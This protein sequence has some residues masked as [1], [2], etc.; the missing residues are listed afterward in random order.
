MTV[1]VVRDI[2]FGVSMANQ[3]PRIPIVCSSRANIGIRWHIK[4]FEH[5]EPSFYL[6]VKCFRFNSFLFFLAFILSRSSEPLCR[7]CLWNAMALC[8]ID[9]PHSLFVSMP[10]E[11]SW[12]SSI[13]I[14]WFILF[15]LAVVIAIAL[16][17]RV[18]TFVLSNHLLSFHLNGKMSVLKIRMK[19]SAVQ[20]QEAE[21]TNLLN[22][23]TCHWV[24]NAFKIVGCQNEAKMNTYIERKI[25]FRYGCVRILEHMVAFWSLCIH[26]K[27][28]HFWHSFMY[29]GWLWWWLWWLSVCMLVHQNFNCKRGRIIV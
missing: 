15:L 19:M 27:K 24:W 22:G 17:L 2:V 6:V 20:W 21:E 11:S 12:I 5:A 18:A 28:K 23:I 9:C 7:Q 29:S 10:F 13:F 25:P 16:A 3:T 8:V 26:R 14:F 1:F 4:T